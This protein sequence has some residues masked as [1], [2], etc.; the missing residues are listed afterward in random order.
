[1]FNHRLALAEAVRERGADVSLLAPRDRYAEKLKS[2]GFQWTEVNLDRKSTDPLTEFRSLV[3]ITRVLRR[4][5]PDLIHNFTL[6]PVIYGSLA[7]LVLG[8]PALVNSITGLGYFFSTQGET[9][10]FKRALVR[11]LLRMALSI[12]N[13]TTVFQHQGDLDAYKGMRVVPSSKA[14]IIPGS[15]IDVDQ[16]R[17]RPEPEDPVVVLMAGRML[18]DK[19]VAVI[20]DASRMLKNQGNSFRVALVGQPDPGNPSSISETQ[21]RDWEREGVA[22]WW[23]YRDDMPDVYGSCHIVVLPSF[24]EGVPRVLLEA[25]AMGKPLIA[26]DLPGCREVISDGENGYLF[27]AGDARALADSISSLVHDRKLRQK[28]GEKGRDIVLERFTNEIINE[29][30]VQVYQELL[31][32]RSGFVD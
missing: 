22:E 3:Q 7:S 20:A 28:M 13:R 17:P 16:F 5:K 2:A 11:P 12:G 18:W 21:L 24:A 25:A 8:V 31:G 30:T 26:S 6:K 9:L 23:G 32:E 4:L 1:L 14:T 10:A 29:R 27:P 19:G 15:G